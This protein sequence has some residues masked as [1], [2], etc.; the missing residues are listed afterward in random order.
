[1]NIICEIGKNFIDTAEELSVQDNLLKAHNMVSE[2]EAIGATIVKFQCHV[3]E[4]EKKKRGEIRYDWIQ[5]NERATPYD[6][7]WVPLKKICDDVGVEFLCTPMSTLAAEKINPLV[8][9][10]KMGSADITDF[11]MLGYMKETGKPIIL[12]TGMSTAEQIDNAIN[13]LGTQVELINYCI[14]IYPCDVWKINLAKML[15]LKK[16]GL[17]IGFSDHSL[18]V[19]IPALAIR[20]GAT[21]IEKHFTFDRGAFGPDHKISLLPNEFKQMVELCEKAS[22]YGETF[23]E[24][25]EYW[26]K[27]RTG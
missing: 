18:S 16:Y 24:E 23:E 6:E 9:R 21:A 25:K 7:F 10:W 12:S 14:S 27:F 15:E 1:M 17:P 26:S 22:M 8:K 20:M 3:F 19:E 11:E 4:D 13:F 2:A 5:R